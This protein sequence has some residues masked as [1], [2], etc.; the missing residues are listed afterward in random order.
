M[1]KILLSLIVALTSLFQA[2]AQD[3]ALPMD[4][5]VRKGVLPNG[6][7]YYLRHNEWP[8]KR[9]FFYIAQKVGSIQ[10]EEDQRGLAHFLEHMCFNGT[11]NF[12]GDRLKQYLETIGVKF[13]ENLN[14]Y[15]S[16]DE[17]VYNIDN[18]NVETAGAIDSCLLIL[19]DWSHDLLLEDK[20]IDKERGVINEE[21][22]TRSSAMMRMYEKGLPEM[23]PGSK[24]GNRLPIG[25][26]DVVLNFPYE[27]LRSYYH[28]WY[29]PDLQAIVVVGDFSV[30]EMEAKIQ[31]MFAD[32][33]PADAD[34]AKFEY[35]PVPDNAEPIVTI[36]KDKEQR[37]NVIDFSWKTE[38]F[39]IEM[40]NT[41]SYYMFHVLRS[42][43]SS[44]FSERISDI[45]QKENAPF[46]HAGFGYGTFAVSKTKD[47]FNCNV[48]CEDNKYE[49][50]VK[51]MLR[52]VFR[53]KQHGYNASE[54]ERFKSKIL[55]SVENAYLHRDK[56]QSANYVNECVRQFIDNEPMPGIVWEYQTLNQFMPQLT[57]EMVN[58]M[59]GQMPDSN[60]VV[61]MFAVDKEDNILPTKEDLLRWMDEVKA[62]NIEPLQEAMNNE[63]LIEKL[64]KP[65][66]VKKIQDDKYGAK[67]ITLSNGV[68][69][70]V[71]KTNFSPNQIS[72]F[73][74]SWGGE[75]LYDM[76][77]YDQVSSVGLVDVGGLG[78][79]SATELN[80]KLAGKQVKVTTNVN[81]REEIVSGNSV[82]KDFETMLQLTYLKFTAPR[83]DVEAFNSAVQRSKA[84]LKNQE[85]QPTTALQDTIAKVVYNNNKRAMR[86]RPE[87]YDKINYDRIIEIYRERY[88]DADDFEFFIVGDCDADS[89]AP[90]LA[91]YLGALPTKK[92]SE[93]YKMIDLKISEGEITNI[94][95]KHQETPSA[96][97]LFLYHAETPYNLKNTI[98]LSMLDQIMDM[99]YTES[100]RE[101]EGGA[102]GVP[103]NA[104]LQ[105]YPKEEA[106]IQIQ[107]PTAPE[108]RERMTHL[109]YQGI[110][111]M[112]TEG[113][114][115]EDLQKVKEYM[116]R[117]HE[118]NLKKNGYWM[119]QMI[120]W[121]L[122]QND[123]DAIYVDTVNSISVADIQEM[124]R[125]ILRSGNRIEVGMTSPA[126][127]M[128]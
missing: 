54:F 95:E 76:S 117:A 61:A 24:Y 96:I 66:K 85:L 89:I 119:N 7:T 77:E 65:G 2:S 26:M 92:G 83:K 10:E 32:I 122:Y 40:K 102:Y 44:M 19:H 111:K 45:L 55:S 38:A 4:S 91:Q 106:T 37:N 104:G 11:K 16:F 9:A 71:K 69:V 25:T 73:A 81:T 13:G 107:L 87:D 58:E 35:F 33:K 30:E 14:A 110:D 3:M 94:F 28:K 20:E 62:E 112:V 100:V 64:P 50:G 5:A 48:V 108:K 82:K 53:V 70:H 90:M 99:M 21:W 127:D 84:N 47:A 43:M 15:T 42:A 88:A 17:T 74:Q 72:M 78:N 41:I 63:P 98:M 125:H 114:K 97:V 34:A 52:E 101:D 18:V 80:K 36:N 105:R 113:P 59:V 51:A 1:K 22:R 126:E 128:K 75:S 109:V 118:E 86:T 23:Y 120:E 121:A 67:L 12:P 79:F 123:N 60:L 103:V 93:T 46:L 39:P 115:S 57:V 27:A 31:K 29:R 56:V 8:E 124:A 49:T 6:L 68:K 116:L